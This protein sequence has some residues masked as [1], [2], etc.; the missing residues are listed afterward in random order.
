MFV[1]ARS[2]F[3]LLLRFLDAYVLLL[4]AVLLFQKVRTQNRNKYIHI[5]IIKKRERVSEKATRV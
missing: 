2:F 3:S 4:D 1:E 5:I